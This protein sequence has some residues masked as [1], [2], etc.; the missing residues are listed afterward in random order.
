MEKFTKIKEAESYKVVPAFGPIPINSLTK[1]KDGLSYKNN[2]VKVTF[3][4]KNEEISQ[5]VKFLSKIFESIHV[6]KVYH[7]KAIGEGSLA[8][9]LALQTYYSDM[10]QSLDEFIEVYQGQ[11]DIIEG[12]DIINSENKQE[13][14]VQYFLE[15]CSF[16]KSTKGNA[17]LEEDTHLFNLIDEMVTIL[18]RTIYKLK[19]LK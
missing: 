2:D 5:P 12:Y 8:K 6:S 7:L 1:E 3:T 13:E 4:D 16:I 14:A 9:H 11:Y 10:S 17:F 15:V 18:Y 19:F